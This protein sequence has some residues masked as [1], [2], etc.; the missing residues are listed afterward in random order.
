MRPLLAKCI[1]SS[2]VTGVKHVP[3][4]LMAAA[5]QNQTEETAGTAEAPHLFLGA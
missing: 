1:Q 3:S 5:T 2:E 4:L